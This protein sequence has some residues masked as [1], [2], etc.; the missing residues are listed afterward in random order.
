MVACICAQ[1]DERGRIG[2]GARECAQV[3]DGVAWSVEEVEGSVAEEVQR[4]KAADLQRG[5]GIIVVDFVAAHKG[6]LA[7]DPTLDITVEHACVGVAGPSWPGRGADAR[8]DDKVGRGRECGGVTDVVE[9]IVRPDDGFDVA[10]S[11][12]QIACI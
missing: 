2:C 9:V 3:A 4:V 1:E 12:A 7:N 11:D 8:P 10:R 6:D 5:R